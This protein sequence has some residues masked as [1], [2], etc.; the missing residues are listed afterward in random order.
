MQCHI[1]WVL[2]DIMMLAT[3]IQKML[4]GCSVIKNII[5]GFGDLIFTGL[6]SSLQTVVSLHLWIV[7]KGMTC[8]WF[9]V[10]VEL[11]VY[12]WINDKLC[13]HCHVIKSGPI[14]M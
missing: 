11:I 2:L 14:I 4:H 10:G 9:H 3:I 8:N 12:K 5:S 7:M 13:P 1:L 6:L